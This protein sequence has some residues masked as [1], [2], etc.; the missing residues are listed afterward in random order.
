MADLLLIE[1]DE[2]QRFVARFALKKAG[3]EVREAADGV[4]GLRLAREEP[5]ELIVCDVMM[6]GVTGYDVL[7]QLRADPRLATVPVIL[8][9]AMSDRKHMRQG[10]TAGAD[11]YLTKPYRP[12]ELIEAVSS[13]V[14]RR[15]V[16]EE[17]FRSSVS[18]LVE[19]A[20]EQQKE[21]LGRHYENQLQREI[22]KRWTQ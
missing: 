12:E 15:Q 17:A 21:T 8:L 19:S 4:E 10:M 2:A 5:P 1:D 3:H 6:P 16:H 9:T 20:L 18:G 7:A 22:N 14:A 13:V 11:D